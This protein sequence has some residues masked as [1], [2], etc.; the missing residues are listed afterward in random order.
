MGCEDAVEGVTLCGGVFTYEY[1]VDGEP[2]MLSRRSG[3]VFAGSNGEVGA[4]WGYIGAVCRGPDNA[5]AEIRQMRARCRVRDAPTRFLTCSWVAAGAQTSHLQ[6]HSRL[7]S[8]LVR[9]MSNLLVGTS[10]CFASRL[11]WYRLVASKAVVCSLPS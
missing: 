10:A 4:R 1:V 11:G 9:L 2:G 7:H 5:W 3:L 6:S 8:F